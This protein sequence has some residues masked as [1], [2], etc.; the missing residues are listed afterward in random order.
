MVTRKKM[1]TPMSMSI[2]VPMAKSMITIMMTR[3]TMVMWIVL[4]MMLAE[5]DDEEAD[6]MTSLLMMEVVFMMRMTIMTW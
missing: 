2:T 6:Y 1:L 4:M 3:V 5:D